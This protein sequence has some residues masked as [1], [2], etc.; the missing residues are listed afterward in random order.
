MCSQI[1]MLVR[2]SAIEP[3]EVG[4]VC[5]ETNNFGGGKLWRGL[6]PIAGR[7][8]VRRYVENNKMR[9]VGQIR[10]VSHGDLQSVPSGSLSHFWR[11]K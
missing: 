6:V 7:S 8:W 1:I 9:E 3:L 4:V 10:T 11:N 2:K 5:N